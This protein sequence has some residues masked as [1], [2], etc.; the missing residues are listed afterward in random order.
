M[1]NVVVDKEGVGVVVFIWVCLLVVGVML[2][3][4]VILY[5]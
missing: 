1:F 4:V 3:I 2:K 5:I